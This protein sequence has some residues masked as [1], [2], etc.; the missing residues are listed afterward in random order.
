MRL[1]EAATTWLE[2][3]YDDDQYRRD[4]LDSY[5]ASLRMFCNYPTTP[6]MLADVTPEHVK[7]WRRALKRRINPRTG[8]EIKAATIYNRLSALT[9][10]FRWCLSEGLIQGSPMEH[11]EKPKL[12]NNGEFI[13][14]HLEDHE[15]REALGKADERTRLM[16]LLSVHLGLRRGELARLAVR[17]LTFNEDRTI[18]V[19]LVRDGKGGKKRSIP[20]AEPELISALVRWLDELESDVQWVFPSRKTGGHLK[21]ERVG[22]LVSAVTPKGRATHA[23]RHTAAVGALRRTSDVERLRKMLGHANIQ[24]TQRYVEGDSADLLDLVTGRTYT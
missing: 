7:L 12:R 21:P 2:G 5:S 10:F 1:Q 18:G 20:M 4:T 22:Q 23:Y 8:E 6:E 13:Q 17:D 19:L 3:K 16:I 15:V 11:I 14:K 24:T 9:S